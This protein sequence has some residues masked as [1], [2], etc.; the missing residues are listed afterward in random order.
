MAVVTSIE[1]FEADFKAATA[2]HGAR[3]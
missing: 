1:R 3:A 2:K